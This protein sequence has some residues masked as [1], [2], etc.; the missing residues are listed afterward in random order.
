MYSDTDIWDTL[1]DI[2]GERNTYK[3]DSEL[4]DLHRVAISWKNVGLLPLVSV[5]RK[6]G[7]DRMNFT[8]TQVNF[9]SS[10]S[11][12]INLGYLLGVPS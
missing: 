5:K 6:Y 4:H 3:S 9:F 1:N 8:I 12:K 10:R 11:I 2:G 7:G